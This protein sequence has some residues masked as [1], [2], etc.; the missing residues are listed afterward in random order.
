MNESE[1]LEF[2]EVDTYWAKIYIAGD[3]RDIESCCRKFCMKG[4]C[5]T[6]RENRF[7][8]T[9]GQE[10]GAEVGLVNY[11]RFPSCPDG[12]FINARGLAIKLID[13]CCQLSALIVMPD[14]TIWIS[15]RKRFEG[16]TR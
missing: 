4:L 15:K 11:P 12:I 13:D 10:D 1:S 14:K 3:I 8:Y 6:V 2:K 7:I 16:K 9:G 5:V